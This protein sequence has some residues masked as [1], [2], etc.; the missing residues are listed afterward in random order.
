M[1]ENAK[2]S[3][4][5]IC[6]WKVL[7]AV[8][9]SSRDTNVLGMMWSPRLFTMSQSPGSKASTHSLEVQWLDKVESRSVMARMSSKKFAVLWYP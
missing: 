9:T 8:A 1:Y 6:G 3:M 5:G 2:G 7:K 4:K